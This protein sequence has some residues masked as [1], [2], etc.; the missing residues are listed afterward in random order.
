M[1]YHNCREETRRC[2]EALLGE[3][4]A[5]AELRVCV[6]D[7]GSTDGTIAVIS[8]IDT[9]IRVLSGSGE[10][11]W[12]AGMAMAERAPMCDDPDLLFWLNDDNEIESSSVGIIPHRYLSAQSWRL[13]YG[14]YDVGFVSFR[15]NDAGAACA[16]RWAARCLDW[17]KDK[18]DTGRFADQGYLNG[19][20][21]PS[22]VS[23]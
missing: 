10:L 7:E 11:Y 6:T 1:T 12:A 20:G 19:F 15:L 14:T 16:D 13:K 17:C 2:L 5:N 9:P 3:D 21:P 22:K 4:L 18:P 8:A 23:A